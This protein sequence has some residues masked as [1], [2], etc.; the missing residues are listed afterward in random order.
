MFHS[1]PTNDT[2]V[3]RVKWELSMKGFGGL[4][5]TGQNVFLGHLGLLVYIKGLSMG[6][7]PSHTQHLSN[8]GASQTQEG[9]L[10]YHSKKKREIRWKKKKKKNA[11]AFSLAIWDIISPCK[12]YSFVR[13]S[14]LEAEVPV[15]PLWQAPASLCC[16][17]LV[18]P[19]HRFDGQHQKSSRSSVASVSALL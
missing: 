19:E 11:K 5:Q 13:C 14:L 17:A 15:L 12:Q 3:A 2:E 18:V 1:Q 6:P 9:F 7:F 4:Q 16:T 10:K 8:W